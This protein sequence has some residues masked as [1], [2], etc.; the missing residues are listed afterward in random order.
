MRPPPEK[1]IHRLFHAWFKGKKWTTPVD[2]FFAGYNLCWKQ[3]E[4][5][6]KSE[7]GSDE[8]GL[9]KQ[10]SLRDKIQE[11]YPPLDIGREHDREG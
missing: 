4:E 8:I 7:I 6:V 3:F 11:R 10:G 1:E 5:F 9:E 2:S